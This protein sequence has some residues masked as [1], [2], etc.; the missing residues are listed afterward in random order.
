MEIDTRITREILLLL[1]NRHGKE[2]I[3]GYIKTNDPTLE[4]IAGD[5][6]LMMTHLLW[7]Q[8]QG[9]IGLIEELIPLGEQGASHVVLMDSG[10]KIARSLKE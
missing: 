4:K 8:R 5:K 2:A 6:K 9:Y 1:L 3:Y 7:L 10:L